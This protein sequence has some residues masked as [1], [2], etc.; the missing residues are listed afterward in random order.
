MMKPFYIIDF[1]RIL[2]SYFVFFCIIKMPTVFCGF[3]FRFAY[4]HFGISVQLHQNMEK[5]VFINSFCA[6]YLSVLT[7]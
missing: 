3:L 7:L 6:K 5:W 4:L 1:L 2:L